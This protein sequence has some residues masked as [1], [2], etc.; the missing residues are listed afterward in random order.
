MRLEGKVALI[1]GSSRGIGAATALKMAEEGADII[2]N[3]FCCRKREC[4]RS[5]G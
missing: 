4:C 2:I 3:F 5:K 1:T